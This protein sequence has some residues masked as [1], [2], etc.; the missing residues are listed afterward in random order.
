MK[1]LFA[2]ALLLAASPAAAQTVETAQG[3]WSSIPEM[4]HQNGAV[5]EA[6]AIAAIAEAMER[7]CTVS[8]QH[9]GNLDLTMPFLVL[10]K[11]DGSVE[12][13]VIRPMG[14][15][16]A[17]GLFAGAVLRLVQRGGFTPRGQRRAGWF[18]G[19]IGFNI[20]SNG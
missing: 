13:L 17:E 4:Q 7:G 11:A 20:S 12:R 15:A 16:R 8:G 19:E 18:R 14:C 3:D 6:D 9:H 1:H 10:F 5:I 2:A